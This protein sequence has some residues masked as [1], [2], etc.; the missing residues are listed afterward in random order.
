[1]PPKLFIVNEKFKPEWTSCVLVAKFS[2]LVPESSL[3]LTSW[4]DAAKCFLIN[5]WVLSIEGE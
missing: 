3:G 2:N 5:H 4:A 1:M